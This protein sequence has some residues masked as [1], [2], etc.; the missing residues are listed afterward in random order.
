MK[1]SNLTQAEFIEAFNKAGRKTQFSIDG[2]KALY[3]HLTDFEEA[4]DEE[5]ELDVIALCCDYTEYDS[6]SLID[7]YGSHIDVEDIIARGDS[8]I[9]ALMQYLENNTD[10]IPVGKSDYII[11]GF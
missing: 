9:E 1:K 2:I 8:Y 4:N 6:Q 5:L 3:E 11:R 7:T 10:V